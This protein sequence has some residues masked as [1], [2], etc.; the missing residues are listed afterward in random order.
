M[1]ENN[2]NNLSNKEMVNEQESINQKI[3]GENRKALPLFIMIVLIG[4]F[5]GLFSQQFA[6]IIS[7]QLNIRNWID[8]I[9]IYSEKYTTVAIWI[10]A[11]ILSTIS[12]FLYRK[13]YLEFQSWNFE[14]ETLIKKVE[15]KISW[16]IL[17][18][19]IQMLS[20]YFFFL[21]QLIV[22]KKMNLILLIGFLVSILTVILLQQKA[23][24][25]NRKINPEKKGSIYDFHF[26]KK[27]INSCDELEQK[28]IGQSAF[29]SYTN[30]N[31]SCIIIFVLLILLST[32]IE[33]DL[34]TVC[35]VMILWS[36]N[37]I[38]FSI[39]AMKLERK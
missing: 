21:L 18:E 6:D 8:T 36:V 2:H 30:V 7:N 33:V 25:L 16:I 35:I 32:V 26:Q 23:V 29:K 10:I 13:S 4:F 27:F 14:D 38:T 3:K 1:K 17:L 34:L 24:D 9:K 28:L 5:I 20:A 39:E 22:A 11:I 15:N 19:N 37:L 31:L 12:I